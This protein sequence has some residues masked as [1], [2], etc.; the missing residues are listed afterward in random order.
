MGPFDIP[1]MVNGAFDVSVN[2]VLLLKFTH[3]YHRKRKWSQ[4]KMIPRRR[5][6]RC[7]IDSRRGVAYTR[8]INYIIDQSW[9]KLQIPTCW[10]TEF[11]CCL[12]SFRGIQGVIDMLSRQNGPQSLSKS[13]IRHPFWLARNLRNDICVI[14][15]TVPRK[16]LFRRTGPQWPERAME[17]NGLF[18]VFLIQNSLSRVPR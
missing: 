16:A 9:P 8:I 7:E 3:L 6:A 13:E 15:I 4:A 5:K 14:S 12:F 18:R 2:F 11:L 10:Y 17:N 1:C